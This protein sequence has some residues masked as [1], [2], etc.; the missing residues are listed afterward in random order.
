MNTQETKQYLTTIYK[1]LLFTQH[2]LD[3]E[4]SNQSTAYSVIAV[5]M[6]SI[7]AMQIKLNQEELPD[8]YNYFLDL[9]ETLQSLDVTFKQNRLAAYKL[10]KVITLLSDN[11]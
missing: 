1:S 6:L 5:S 8:I 4:Q 9:L 7:E 10:T 3:T 11:V 2:S